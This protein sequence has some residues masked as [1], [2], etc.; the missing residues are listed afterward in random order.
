VSQ[1]QTVALLTKQSPAGDDQKPSIRQKINA[2]RKRLDPGD[3]LARS[4]QIDCDDL[5]RAPVGDDQT[6]IVPTRRL[7]ERETVDQELRHHSLRLHRAAKLIAA[8]ARRK[9]IGATRADAT[10][11]RAG[12]LR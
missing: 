7:R 2:H 6:A 4:S 9:R 12:R 11:C 10:G 5:L 3:D 1:E 8:M